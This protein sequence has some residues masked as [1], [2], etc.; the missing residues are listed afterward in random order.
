MKRLTYFYRRKNPVFFSLEQVFGRIAHELA[1][2]F[3]NEYAVRE[4]CAPFPSKLST[5]L[6]NIRWARREQGDI[7]HITGDIHYVLLGFSR[8]KVNVLTIHDCVRLR[9]LSRT[10]PRYWVIKWLWHEWPMRRADVITTISESTKNDLLRFTSCTP[11]KIRVIPNYIDP[12]FRPGPPRPF[13]NPPRILFVGTTENK[14]LDRLAQAMEGIPAELDIIGVLNERQTACLRRHG[15]AYTQCSGISR[16]ALLEHY[17]GCDL[18]AFPSTY[19]GFGLPVLEGQAVGR[20]VLTSDLSPMRE[21]AGDGAC[22]VDP[23]DAGSIREGLL[24]MIGDSAYR[25]QLVR[26]G[27]ANAGGYSLGNIVAS[28]ARLYAGLLEKKL[29]DHRSKR[30]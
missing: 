2:G 29:N 21:I 4:V 20:P 17:H 11:E 10:D 30:E 26:S 19:E 23:Y 14:N 25:D 13:G 7:N 1:A 18:V 16:E 12:D 8:K 6:P 22:L 3:K 5:L 15:I 9:S 28:Y 24:R 27:L